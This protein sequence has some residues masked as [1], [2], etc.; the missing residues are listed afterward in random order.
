MTFF[1]AGPIG[2]VAEKCVVSATGA[3]RGSAFPEKKIG[4][5]VG[6]Y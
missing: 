1:L 6:F 4:F 5:K 2:V 3:A